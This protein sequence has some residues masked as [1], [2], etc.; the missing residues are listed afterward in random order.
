MTVVYPIITILGI[1][2]YW[3]ILGIMGSIVLR[4][5]LKYLRSIFL[6]SSIGSFF[7]LLYSGLSLNQ[8]S[9]NIVL[10]LGVPGY[11]FHLHWDPLSGFF[12]V[13]LSITSL[14]VSLFSS[15]YFRHLTFRTQSMICF[16]YHLFLASMAWVLIAADA[17]SFLIA[18]ELMALSSYFLIVAFQS[19][20]ENQHAGF[21]YLLIAHI[22]ALSILLSFALILQGQNDF[23][24]DHIR[25]VNLSS[26]YLNMAV[27][28]ALIGFGAKAGLL[29]FHIWLPEAH[30]AAPS[31]ISALMSG[32]MLK[33]AIYGILRISFDL[34]P[35]KEISWGVVLLI[36]GLLTALFGVILAAMQTDMKR[37]LAYSSIEN[38]GLIFTGIGLSQL[39][40]A[41]NHTQLA[42]L[43]LVAVL[44]LCFNHALLKCLLFLG[45]GS[46]LHATEERNLGRLGG[47]I[48]RM[49]WVATLILIGVLGMAGVPML[50]GFVAEW[51]LLQSFLLSPKI[52]I[53]SLIMI[54]PIAAAIVVLVIGLSAYVMIKFYGIIFLGKPRESHLVKVVDASALEKFGLIWFAG[55]CLVL[56]LFPIILI[57]PLINIADFLLHAISPA[58]PLFQVKHSWLFLVPIQ[59]ERASYSPFIFFCVIIAFYMI[60]FILIRTFYH[61]RLIRTHAWDGGYPGQTARMQDTAEGFSQPIKQIFK[62][63]LHI[64]LKVPAAEDKHPQY[65]MYAADRFWYVLYFPLERSIFYIAK[66]ISKLQHGRISYYLMYSFITLLIL[67]WWVL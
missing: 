64:Q 67:L 56:G 47:L 38:I 46:V 41:S 8:T 45:T 23:S 61:G 16:N 26:I 20:Q 5:Q 21:L 19:T 6:L 63:F 7:L 29:P 9:S 50:N 66:W 52:S 40:N 55:I 39:F 13:V 24:F 51:L 65:Q 60:L 53:S 28:F 58:S 42:A 31:P 54:L 2:C 1:I 4:I 43:T 33:I 17:Y 59:A 34:L 36:M 30:P 27:L 37:L 48:S 25:Q 15:D 11:P 18:W 32:V 22:G 35:G 12:L 10:N 62:S 49:P 44:F 3:F 57:H 14:G